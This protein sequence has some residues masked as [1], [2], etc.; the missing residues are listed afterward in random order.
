MAPAASLNPDFLAPVL[1]PSEAWRFPAY[2]RAFLGRGKPLLAP[3]PAEWLLRPWLPASYVEWRY[4]SVLAA[5]FHGIVGLAIFNPFNRFAALA[6]S[7][8]LLIIA[9]V[10]DAPRS[11]AEVR[12][13]REQGGLRQI[14]WMHLFPTASLEFTAEG[15]EVLRAEHAG[16]ELRA[17]NYTTQYGSVALRAEKSLA[18]VLEHR[19]LEG[20]EIAPCYANDQGGLPGEHWIVYNPSP[21]AEATG[22]LRLAPQFLE[23]L[24]ATGQGG[25]FP[26]FV[27]PALRRE[28]ARAGAAVRWHKANGYYEH[29]F[30]VRPLPLNGWDFL[31]VPDAERRQGL[32]LQTYRNSRIL[33]YIEVF[34][35][36][37]GQPRYTRFTADEL[38]LDWS[39]S[40]ADP[41]TG[42]QLPARRTLTARRPGLRLEVTNDIPHHIPF[43]RPAKLAVRHFFISEQIGFCTWRLSDEAGGVLA[44]A[45]EQPAGGEVAHAR[46]RVPRLR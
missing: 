17:R 31:F 8:L 29:S 33:R 18:L 20:T 5:G 28:I 22:E 25:T 32:V 12:H 10:L 45:H 41:D 7:G 11:A 38:H 2:A 40:F 37:E 27:S 34:W 21:I 23:R 43:L 14:C 13:L 9:G 3:S 36:Q 39:L 15:I 6:E 42:T 46:L 1:A 30:G 4:Y 24:D 19:G 35:Q 16:V 26:N 44:E